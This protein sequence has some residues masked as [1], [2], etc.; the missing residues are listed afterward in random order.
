MSIPRK[1]NITCSHCGM[2]FDAWAWDSINLES[3]PEASNK[4]LKKDYFKNICPNCGNDEIDPYSM[5]CYDQSM[6][7]FI[8]YWRAEDSERFFYV[9]ELLKEGQ[10][11]CHVFSIEDLAEKVLAIQNGRDDRIV[12]M[13]KFW[14]LLKFAKYLPQFSLERLY[15]SVENDREVIIGVDSN[16]AKA[17]VDFPEKVYRQFEE[18]FKNSLPRA[19]A[20]NMIYDTE[21]A[22]GFVREHLNALLE[23]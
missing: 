11:L 10:R 18:A 23:S 13:C 22:D 9:D 4:L 21:W 5:I 14:V 20:K 8:E 19:K 2:K 17:T 12:E 3:H 15:Y 7:V 1:R 16:C 6:G